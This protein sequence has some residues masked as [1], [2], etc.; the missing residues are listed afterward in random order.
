MDRKKIICPFHKESVPSLVVDTKT[1]KAHCFGCD[2][3]YTLS[4]VEDAY[5]NYPKARGLTF[6]EW[7]VELKEWVVK[8]GMDKDGFDPETLDQEDW[9]C[10]YEDGYA[11]G[12]ALMEDLTNG[13]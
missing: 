13:I 7:F 9:K 3:D 2:K 8:L 1:K 6:D 11:P 5:R 12:A 10:F 4:Q